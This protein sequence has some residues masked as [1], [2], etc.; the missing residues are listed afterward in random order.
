MI[1]GRQRSEKE[2]KH[3]CL[4]AFMFLKTCLW[5]EKKKKHNL[6]LKCSFNKH[7]WDFPCGPVVKIPFF[8]CKEHRFDP[9]SRN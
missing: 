8:H 4:L 9:W 6:P 7:S 5:G 1:L 3:H 2:N